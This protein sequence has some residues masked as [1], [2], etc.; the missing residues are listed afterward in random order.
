M[1]ELLHRSRPSQ[2]VSLDAW[3]VAVLTS[4]LICQAWP[5]ATDLIW[6]TAHW[7]LPS[8]WLSYAWPAPLLLGVWRSLV[9]FTTVY[10]VTD[11]RVM[12]RRG[13]LN[14]HW[15]EVELSRILDY[16]VTQPLHLRIFGLGNLVIVS[17]DK[18]TPRLKILAQRHVRE[19]RDG[20]RGV[21]LDRQKSLGHRE[22]YSSHS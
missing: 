4:W 9:I 11:Q 6:Q 1:E 12:R 18:T 13:I 7:R 15:D 16:V 20:I 3:G 10:K 8:A 19:L 5:F 17:A 14:V 22:I 2:I 21:V